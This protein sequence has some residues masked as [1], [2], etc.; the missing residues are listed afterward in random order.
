M[1]RREIPTRVIDAP[2]VVDDE[3]L[4]LRNVAW[5]ERHTPG[6]KE[7]SVSLDGHAEPAADGC[8]SWRAARENRQVQQRG[9]GCCDQCIERAHRAMADQMLAWEG[10]ARGCDGIRRVESRQGTELRR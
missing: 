5:R 6:G 9:L 7:A 1:P 8:S 2:T 3:R 10:A 4:V